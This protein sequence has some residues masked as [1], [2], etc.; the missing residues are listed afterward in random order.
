M[1][2][3]RESLAA[4]IAEVEELAVT[5][6][7]PCSESIGLVCAAASEYLIQ[8]STSPV[9]W[10]YDWHAGKTLNRDWV[11]TNKAETTLPTCEDVRPLYIG[12]QKAEAECKL[13][14]EDVAEMRQMCS[15]RDGNAQG[16][17]SLLLARMLVD[18]GWKD[19]VK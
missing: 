9:A 18:A 7:T 16:H 4:A 13:Q 6:N 3:H 17:Y 10:M 2:I 11:T 5:L 14:P 1:K 12:V 15:R 19:E 8:P